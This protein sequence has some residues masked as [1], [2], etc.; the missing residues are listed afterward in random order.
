VGGGWTLVSM[1]AFA[2]RPLDEVAARTIIAWRYPPP[3][4]VYD[5][6]VSPDQRDL[7]EAEVAFYT[8]ARNAY[9]GM[10][11]LDA[12]GGEELEAFCC[13]GHDARVPGGDY[14]ADAL[15][16]GLGVRPDLT[17]RGRGRV[18]A[19]AVIE[20]AVET[21]RPAQLRATIAAF[22]TRALRVWEHHHGFRRVGEF[23]KAGEGTRF[24]LLIQTCLLGTI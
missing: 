4:D 22:N 18:Y 19:G 11:A 12:S 7:L 8:D 16:L 6:A 14:S 24:V 17:G 15:D 5:V 2:F 13:F 3:Y 23:A 9:F 21:F 10:Y 20:H 1:P